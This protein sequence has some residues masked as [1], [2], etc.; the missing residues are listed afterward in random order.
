MEWIMIFIMKAL[1]MLAYILALLSPFILIGWFFAGRHHERQRNKL[2]L[3]R[4]RRDRVA[5]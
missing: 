5:T 3:G 2:R 1:T 4:D